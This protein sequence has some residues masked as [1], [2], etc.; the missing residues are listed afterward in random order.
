M[1]LL[2]L[3]ILAQDEFE[4]F[5]P[6]PTGAAKAKARYEANLKA[7]KGNADMLVLPGLVADRKER[8]VEVLAES[9]GLA[10]EETA[11]FL[12]IGQES[13]HGYEALLWS[14]AKP[15]DVHRALEFIGLKPGTPVNPAMLRFW[16][17]GDRVNLDIRE[18]GGTNTIPIEQLILDTETGETL[19]EEGFIFTGSIM[20]RPRQGQ[21]KPQ[22]A[23]DEFDPRS[24]ASIYN[25]PAAVLD[26][27][28]QVS[29]GEVYGKQVVNPEAVFEHGDLLTVVM[30]PGATDG[31]PRARQFRLSIDYSTSATGVVCRLKENGSE[32]AGA[33]CKFSAALEELAA[34]QKEGVA[35]YID[36]SFGDNLP[37]DQAARACTMLAMVEAMGIARINP[38]AEGQLYYRAFVPNKQWL[39][40][41]GRPTQPWELH[42]ARKK[43][44][45]AAE[46]VWHEA[47]WSDDSI[48]PTFKRKAFAVPNPAAVKS[49]ADAEAEARS[50][51]GKSPLPAVLLVF[52][53]AD[54]TY[55]Q[56]MAFVRPVLD[57]HGTVYVFVEQ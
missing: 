16:A 11:E 20:V 5:G 10:A 22:Y 39:K 36:P 34:V 25:E 55:G 12:L 27:P 49:R 21:D 45:T 56:V 40:P 1:M 51:A 46:L 9:T 44:K 35:P 24:V 2:P 13:S 54:M 43:G 32:T 30:T 7:H 29:Q 42:L 4:D 23:A 37:V 15:S 47:I 48:E 38:P 6:Q 41:E 33:P 17:D 53:G 57:T 8:T 50:K 28:R 19:P 26:V 52:A 3:A 31:Q 14:F 18:D